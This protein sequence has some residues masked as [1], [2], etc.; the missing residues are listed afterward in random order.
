MHM[1][2]YGYA[3]KWRAIGP[4]F[5]PNFWESADFDPTSIVAD[6]TQLWFSNPA[7]GTVTV[8][9][10][11]AFLGGE[12]SMN[13]G[14]STQ[15]WPQRS[16]FKQSVRAVNRCHP[17]SSPT[18]GPGWPTKIGTSTDI[19]P[20][21]F[22]YPQLNVIKMSLVGGWATPLKNMK[23][24]WDDDIPNIW[25]NNIDVP[26]HQPD[27]MS[28]HCWCFWSMKNIASQ[29]E[30]LDEAPIVSREWRDVVFFPRK[31]FP[32]L[33]LHKSAPLSSVIWVGE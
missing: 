20:Q 15:F 12:S 21:I 26:N 18:V 32:S 17:R 11:I 30:W 16:Y 14:Y 29:C 33:A 8:P 2:E 28:E 6:M 1:N 5:I 25:E 9:P 22:S 13:H 19:P 7:S 27:K 31:T 23:V 24:N 3:S 4:H 10:S